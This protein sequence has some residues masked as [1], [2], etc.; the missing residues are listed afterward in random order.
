[1]SYD[2]TQSQDNDD[3]FDRI[4]KEIRQNFKKGQADLNTTK[5]PTL[6][7]ELMISHFKSPETFWNAIQ[8]IAKKQ[9]D[10]VKLLENTNN[11]NPTVA[12]I[13]NTNNNGNQKNYYKYHLSIVIQSDSDSDDEQNQDNNNTNDDDNKSNANES[14]EDELDAGDY[15]NLYYLSFVLAFDYTYLICLVVFTTAY[16]SILLLDLTCTIYSKIYY[17]NNCNNLW[18]I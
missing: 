17:R 18:W 2:T 6:S 14:E 7:C 16:F 10:N 5:I 12:I 11:D 8:M 9:G 4:D 13:P 3:M 15:K 1:M